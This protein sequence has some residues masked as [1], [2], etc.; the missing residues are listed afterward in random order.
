MCAPLLQVYNNSILL[1]NG[2][3]LIAGHVKPGVGGE[4]GLYHYHE[5][6]TPEIE[7]IKGP[8]EKQDLVHVGFAMD[9]YLMYYS[10]S[11]EYQ[12]S[13][14]L[15]TEPRTSACTFTLP[16][17]A[18]GTVDLGLTPNGDLQED[19]VYTEGGCCPHLL[20]A[21]LSHVLENDVLFPEFI[22]STATSAM[23]GF[24][25]QMLCTLPLPQQGCGIALCTNA[26]VNCALLA[27]G[28]F[29]VRPKGEPSASF[30]PALNELRRPGAAL[31]STGSPPRRRVKL[32]CKS[33]CTI[34]ESMKWMAQ[35][36]E[37]MPGTSRREPSFQ[38]ACCIQAQ[39]EFFIQLTNS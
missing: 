4:N 32:S 3:D 7:V 38:G 28:L 22:G 17:S 34:L 16:D 14:A 2:D 26:A 30:C 21:G 35:A 9:G 1:A 25:R 37:A 31:T 27:S 5:V 15:S 11:G 23:Q 24:M 20:C 10:R 8:D 19:W 12:S 13:Y 33:T 39:E 6:M 36:E 29:F 18:S